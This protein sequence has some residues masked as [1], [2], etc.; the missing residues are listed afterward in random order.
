MITWREGDVAME[1]LRLRSTA[2]QEKT[3]CR[4]LAGLFHRTSG[5]R[6]PVKATNLPLID[7]DTAVYV[8]DP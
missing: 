2:I 1:R 6:L 4:L 8:H 3:K 5:A 7:N